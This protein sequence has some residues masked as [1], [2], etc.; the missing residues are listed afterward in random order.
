MQPKH[1]VVSEEAI[2]GE[3]SRK[4]DAIF[5]TEHDTDQ[6]GSRNVGAIGLE[7]STVRQRLAVDTLCLDSSVEE[8]IGDRDDD[9]IDDLCGSDDVGEP[10]ENDHGRIGESQEIQEGE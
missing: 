9:V 2:D 8:D 4:E 10:G 1:G 3:V 5:I 6:K 7:S